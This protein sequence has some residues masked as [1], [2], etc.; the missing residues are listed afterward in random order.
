MLKNPGLLVG[1]HV[2]L[3]LGFLKAN[4]RAKIGAHLLGNMFIFHRGSS[5]DGCFLFEILK[6]ILVYMADSRRT[7]THFQHFRHHIASECQQTYPKVVFQTKMFEVHKKQLN[8]V[9]FQAFLLA[10]LS[11]RF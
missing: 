2:L 4:P 6:Q 1:D 5:S 8:N 11:Q 10:F 3:F 7:K 9:F